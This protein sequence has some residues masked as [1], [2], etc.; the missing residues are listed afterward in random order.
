MIPRRA[1]SL[2][3]PLSLVQEGLAQVQLAT[4][5]PWYATISC[6]AVALR[7]AILPTVVYQVRQTRRLVALR[8]RF[9]VLRRECADI[10]SPN[11][12]AWALAT[13]LWAECRRNDVQP[14]SIIGLPLMQIPLLIGLLVSVRRLLLPE[15]P[16]AAALRKGGTHWF[17]DL[18]VPDPTAT[19]PV[20]SLLVLVT[21]L[22][23]SFSTGRSGG[24]LQGLRNFAQAGAVIGLPFY[25]EL[26]AGLF[27]YW[28]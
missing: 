8:P 3:A 4:G 23:L 9:A 28:L 18:T 10:A 25:A 21:N 2:D 17:R 15:S 22:Q 24:V 7:V 12:R 16:Y 20:L 27:M 6:S 5:L 26:P 13:R 19:L 1:L 14:L 11:E